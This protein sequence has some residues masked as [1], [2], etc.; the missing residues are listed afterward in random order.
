MPLLP[1]VAPLTLALGLALTSCSQLRTPPPITAPVRGVPGFTVDHAF[2][3]AYWYSRYNM[4]S[5]NMQSG[6]GETFMPPAG[7]MDALVNVASDSLSTAMPPANPAMVSRIYTLGNPAL[8]NAFNGNAMDFQNFRWTPLP[9][10]QQAQTSAAAFAWTLTK[11]VEWDRQFQV[12]AHFGV[13]GVNDTIPGAQERFAGLALFV[14]AMMMTQQY[15]THP[16]GFDS[17]DVGGQYA[18]LMAFADLNSLLSTPALLYSSGNRYRD[19]A[20][21]LAQMAG[22]DVPGFM[23]GLQNASGMLVSTLPVASTIP[24]AAVAV[25]AL[26]WY[27][28]VAPDA[29]SASAAVLQRQKARTAAELGYQLRGTLDAWRV[30]GDN[31]YLST[32]A[33]AYLGLED[34]YDSTYGVFTNENIYT[35][36]DVAGILAGLN[37]ALLWLT[38]QHPEISAGRINSLIAGFW[39]GTV[40]MG[41]LQLAAPRPARPW[42]SPYEQQA[43]DLYH[44]Y[45]TQPEPA[46]AG[47]AHGYA[48]VFAR[49]VTW[50]PVNQ[51][52]TV[53]R[54]AFDT[55]GAM[56]LATEGLWLHS[57]E[58]DGFPT[59]K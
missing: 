21:M 45:P 51:K 8:A 46:S 37:A 43:S 34:A 52:W 25:Q 27:L 31:R 57:D 33:R 32:A 20:P 53:D 1:S 39:E 44:R 54:S 55:A 15:M 48:P 14:Q 38:S 50:N 22:M 6:N 11:I 5:L 16:E 3:E 19:A 10:A 29:V 7:A 59:V 4:M 30:T 2:E 9:A 58:V 35:P 23:T 49:S 13:P 28:T 18:V 42:M 41:G 40:D 26:N 56:H 36:S 17:S 24:D 12:D 47:G